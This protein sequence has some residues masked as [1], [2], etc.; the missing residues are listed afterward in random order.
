MIQIKLNMR[1][2]SASRPRVTKYGTFNA[3]KYDNYKK[4]LQAKIRGFKPLP[5]VPLR[6]ELFFGF[7]PSKSA[8]K[9]K[10]PV[11]KYDVDNLA[12]GV[13]DACN[14]IL[15]EDDVLVEELE[16]IKRYADVDCIFITIEEIE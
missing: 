3:K 8:K 5:N 12:K 11:P 16:V 14:G 10:Y 7:I 6:V 4:L 1:G 15:F 9:N 2:V 13:L